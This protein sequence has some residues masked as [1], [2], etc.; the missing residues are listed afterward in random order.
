MVDEHD[1]EGQLD[2]LPH[3][4]VQVMQVDLSQVQ[5]AVVDDHEQLVLMVQQ[6]LDEQ[7]EHDE[8]VQLIRLVVHRLHMQ[9]EVVD[10]ILFVDW[11]GQV[12]EVMGSLMDHEMVVQV[13]LIQVQDE[14]EYRGRDLQ[15]D[16]TVEVVFL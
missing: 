10:D 4:K 7:V 8:M 2:H 16:M 14:V 11:V 13:Q 5:Q 15:H 6:L 1:H 3:H 9:H 12:D